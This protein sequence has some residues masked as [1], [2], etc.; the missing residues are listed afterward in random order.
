LYVLE[1]GST[2]GASN[3]ANFPTGNA[4]TIFVASG[5]S[6]GTYYVRIRAMNAGGTSAP[7]N[8]VVVVVGTPM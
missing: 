7:S 5:V 2:P 4:A 8:E 3:L 1:A 6:A